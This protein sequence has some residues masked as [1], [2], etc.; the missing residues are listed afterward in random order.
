MESLVP[1]GHVTRRAAESANDDS[2]R[3]L[4]SELSQETELIT[5]RQ[6]LF[7][8]FKAMNRTAKVRHYG[9]RNVLN[10]GAPQASEKQA[11]SVTLRDKWQVLTVISTGQC[12][13]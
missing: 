3:S 13:T 1:H 12:N 11:N 8:R 4:F 9:G 10:Y 5:A 7:S 2:R 6:S